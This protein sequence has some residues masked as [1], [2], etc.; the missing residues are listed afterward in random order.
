MAIGIAFAID[1]ANSTLRSINSSR[2]RVHIEHIIA[3]TARSSSAIDTTFPPFFLFLSQVSVTRG[4]RGIKLAGNHHDNTRKATNVMASLAESALSF[5]AD[6][7]IMFYALGPKDM[8]GTAPDYFVKAIPYFF[9]MIGM[10]FAVS[11]ARGNKSLYRKNDTMICLLLGSLQMLL[12]VWTKAM[13]I[14]SYIWVWENLRIMEL[15]TDSWALWALGLLGVDL[16]YYWMHRTA[17]EFH[18]LWSAHSVHHSGEDYN[19]ATSLRQGAFQQVYSWVFKLHCALVLPPVVFAHHT[20]LN[21][22]YQFWIH[23]TYVGDLGP[24]EYIMNTPSHHRMHHRPPGNCNYAGVLIIWDIMFGTFLKED[25][26]K[27]YYGLAKQYETWDPVWANGEHLWRMQAHA[28]P[29]ESRLSPAFYLKLLTKRRVKARWVFRPLDLFKAQ[30]TPVRSLWEGPQGPP[31]RVRYDGLPSAKMSP[32]SFYM[33]FIF[34]QALVG[35]VTVLIFSKHFLQ[36]ELVWV[37]MGCCLLYS[38]IGRLL[39]GF[40]KGRVINTVRIVLSCV[41][42]AW[43][44]TRSNLTENRQIVLFAAYGVQVAAALDALIWPLV[45]SKM[46][47]LVP[48]V[49][50]PAKKV[51]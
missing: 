6:A 50:A 12:G 33:Y 1:I 32:L 49:K 7:R 15:R 22:L 18:V 10:E 43:L 30:A 4:A 37:L 29:N 14:A 34:A 51:E 46:T 41:A 23:T 44:A 31:K 39:D 48:V 19:L 26:Q 36:S 45:H 5:A 28:N 27:D 25:E 47:A 17:H 3:T 9:L 16:G 38:S 2:R 24:L 13:G 8:A 40:E 42:A 21:T 11:I 35:T 20:A